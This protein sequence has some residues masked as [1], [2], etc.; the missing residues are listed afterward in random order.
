MS[1]FNQFKS[2]F[3]DV[4]EHVDQTN[5]LMVYKYQRPGNEIKQGAQVIVRESQVALFMKGG[6][7]AD[8]LYPGTHTLN[9]NNLPI[10]STLMAFKYGF[11]S[12]IKADL[13]FISTKQFIDNKWST[14]NPFMLKDQDFGMV[15]IR[16]FGNFSLRI[17][18]EEVFCKQVL[19]T[20]GKMMTYDIIKYLSAIVTEAVITAIANAKIPVL[21]LATMYRELASVALAVAN[22][23]TIPLGVEV[24]HVVVQNLSLPDEVEKLIDEQ[25]GIG[26]A[27]QNMEVFMQY[28]SA[29]A[30]RDAAKQK[31]GLAGLGAGMA[32]GNKMANS[33]QDVSTKKEDKEKE[34]D[35]AKLREF[36]NLLDEGIITEEEF[37][38]M[39]K[40][41]LGL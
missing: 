24:T 40:Q 13:F 31:G 21:E 18:D 11:N 17:N 3:V 4:I 23:A 36:K 6:E 7:L 20:L 25:S 15:R 38:A 2:Q 27:S 34:V 22:E 26:M 29:R 35:I 28:Q 33:I 16:G 19:G 9:T 32:L 10:L 41:I 37:E 8:I 1:L 30:M 12:P 5:K 14:K 39:K